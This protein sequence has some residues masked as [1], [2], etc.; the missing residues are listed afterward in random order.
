MFDETE[1][2]VIFADVF[3]FL[4]EESRRGNPLQFPVLG[5]PFDESVVL[6]GVRL[7]TQVDLVGQFTPIGHDKVAPF[8]YGRVHAHVG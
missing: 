1:S 8:G 4:M 3:M 5:Q 2:D 7:R 6:L